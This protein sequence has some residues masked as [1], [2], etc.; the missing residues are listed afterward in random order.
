MI[1][2]SRLSMNLP[3]ALRSR[4]HSIVRHVGHALASQQ[5]DVELRLDHLAGVETSVSVHQHD[6]EIGRT[7]AHAIITSAYQRAESSDG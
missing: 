3:D 7:I 2:I 1:H 6:R 4:A 5:V